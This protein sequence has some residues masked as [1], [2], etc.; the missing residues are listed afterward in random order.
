[1]TLQRFALYFING[2]LLLKHYLIMLLCT[3]DLTLVALPKHFLRMPLCALDLTLVWAKSA[4]RYRLSAEQLHP[5][6]KLLDFNVASP[7]LQQPDHYLAG[8]V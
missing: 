5:F 2:A 4:V 7:I 6:Q 1:M 8:A 3:L